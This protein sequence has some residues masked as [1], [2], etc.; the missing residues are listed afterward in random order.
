MIHHLHGNVSFFLSWGDNGDQEC[1]LAQFTVSG[2][3]N[4]FERFFR[5]YDE[6]DDKLSQMESHG[7]M[8]AAAGPGD[9]EGFISYEVDPNDFPNVMVEWQEWFAQQG[10]AVGEIAYTNPVNGTLPDPTPDQQ[11]RADLFDE[12]LDVIRGKVFG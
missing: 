12:A 3:P 7:T 1:M 10:F 2:L 8:D 4:V 5:N 11:T 9:L 6:F